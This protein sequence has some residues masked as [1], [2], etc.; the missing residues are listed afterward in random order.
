VEALSGEGLAETN[1]YKATQE[2][3]EHMD[4]F[5]QMIPNMENETIIDAFKTGADEYLYDKQSAEDCAKSIYGEM[6][7]LAAGE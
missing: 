7:K 4:E 3:N 5:H 2:M 6:K 1:E